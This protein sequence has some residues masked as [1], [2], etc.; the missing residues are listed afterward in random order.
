MKKILTLL[1]FIF[2]V[3]TFNAIAQKD[4]YGNLQ[5]Y[6]N[7]T[8]NDT[9]RL[10]TTPQGTNDTSRYVQLGID[11]LG[12]KVVRLWSAKDNTQINGNLTVNG[13]ITGTMADSLFTTTFINSDL[14]SYSTGVYYLLVN[15]NL[16]HKYVNV[17]VWNNN[18]E[19]VLT[20]FQDSI[21]DANSLIIKDFATLQP[22]SGTWTVTVSYRGIRGITGATGTQG[23]QGVQGITGATGMTGATGLRGVQGITG[24]TGANGITGATGATGANGINGV[25]GATGATG[26]QGIRGITGATG[27][28]GITGATGVT[29]ATGTNGITGATGTQGIRGVTGATGTN[30]VTGVTGAT[31]ATGTNGVTGATGIQG[32]HGVTGATGASGTNGSTGATGLSGA[33]GAT[34]LQGVTG[35]TGA[36]G[37]Q[38]ATGATGATGSGGGGG[39]SLT[40]NPGINPLVNF[41]GTT[42]NAPL[43]FKANGLLAGYIDCD[44]TKGNTY[45]GFNAGSSTV[46]AANCF[47]GF[48]AGTSNV[49]GMEN[50]AIGYASDFVYT[51]LMNAAAIGFNAKASH[52][53]TLILGDTDAYAVN[54]GIGTC[55]PMQKLD[56]EGNVRFREGQYVNEIIVTDTN[57]QILQTEYLVNDSAITHNDTISLPTTAIYGQVIELISNTNS[58]NFTVLKDVNS[59]IAYNN[60]YKQK[61]VTITRAQL[62]YR[63]KMIYSKRNE[64]VV[65]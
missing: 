40:G 7:F 4:V 25:T 45:L 26:L 59:R 61:T 34:G 63:V 47:L 39:W 46:A 56:V 22:I 9:C 29:G 5:V 23:I 65:Y 6:G 57:H 28:N 3:I 49:S 1:F 50:T 43:I 62:P 64:W 2:N 31:G 35:S 36:T 10:L 8:D 24:A 52:N 37:L 48:G 54:V 51:N 60:A 42:D 15:H 38:G 27:I 33:T 13:L 32:V 17:S 30:G 18:N 20:V 53:N 41:L 11:L 19:N 16:K 14:Q 55:T 44:V 21:V 58:V 12:H